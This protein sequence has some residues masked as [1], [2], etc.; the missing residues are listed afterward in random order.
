M[1]APHSIS[2][3]TQILDDYGYDWSWAFVVFREMPEY[4]GY[5]FGSDGA[6][7]TRKQRGRWGV[8]LAEWRRMSPQF[9][10]RLGVHYVTLSDA[11]GVRK[12]RRVSVVI[13]TAFHGPCPA[14]EECCH[15]DG[16][17][18]NNAADN[19][20]WDTR[21]GNMADMVRHGTRLYGERH[22]RA[23]FSDADVEQARRL[24]LA[25]LTPSAISSRVGMS[26]AHV[27]DILKGHTR[28]HATG[29]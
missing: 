11:T 14:G 28:R 26:A 20:R 15:H 13:C 6:I 19:L 16:N 10:R 8:M 3:S 17:P 12:K 23:K 9:N 5:A 24:G 21:T 7:W 27:R 29:D 1:T 22:P 2:P 4:P 18:L 25:G